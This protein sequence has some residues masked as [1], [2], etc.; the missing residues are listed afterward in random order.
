[1]ARPDLYHDDLLSIF[2]EVANFTDFSHLKRCDDPE[3]KI[4]AA[5]EKVRALQAHVKGHLDL[6]KEK[7]QASQRREVAQKKRASSAAFKNKLE[8]IRFDFT[9]TKQRL[10][11]KF[12]LLQPPS[13]IAFKQYQ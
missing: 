12:I 9:K 8:R 7:E 2:R 10:K 3:Q 11:K 5:Q 4:C 6:L 1:L 13:N